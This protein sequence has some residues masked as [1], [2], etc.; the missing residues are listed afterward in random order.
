MNCTDFQLQSSGFSLS[1]SCLFV[2][3]YLSLKYD[4]LFDFCLS[5][6]TINL[7]TFGCAGTIRCDG[8]F[9]GASPVYHIQ[10]WRDSRTS[11]RDR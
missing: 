6:C 9:F 1:L 8:G 3:N 10:S 2:L 4:G 5:Q 11:E 7:V